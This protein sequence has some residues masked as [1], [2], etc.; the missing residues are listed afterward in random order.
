VLT[1]EDQVAA[2]QLAF[3]KTLS[4]VSGDLS[5]YVRGRHFASVRLPVGMPESAAG[6][7]STTLNDEDADLAVADLSLALGR[8]EQA[9][10]IYAK[11]AVRQ[12]HSPAVQQALG[13]LALHRNQDEVA[14]RYYERAIELGSSNGRLRYDYATLL[15]EKGEPEEKVMALLKEA[16][17]LD[18]RLF[19]A[20]HLLGYIALRQELYAESIAAFERAIE[21]QPGR[22]ALWEYLALAYHGSGNRQRAVEAASK[23]RKFASVPEEA[24]RIEATIRQI[25]ESL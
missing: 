12:P 6:V 4:K 16:A 14:R 11:L 2:F 15:R 24:T 10:A 7:S 9:E 23:A 17:R 13:D 25:E 19:E 22:A 21:L 1:G 18:T 3:G 8:H 20:H 5:A